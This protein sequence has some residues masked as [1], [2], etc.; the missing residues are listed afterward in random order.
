M[1]SIPDEDQRSLKEFKKQI[2]EKNQPPPMVL[3]FL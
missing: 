1:D 3:F 2:I